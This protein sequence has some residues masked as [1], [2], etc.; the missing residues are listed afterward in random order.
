[1]PDSTIVSKERSANEE[2]IIKRMCM[3]GISHLK[4][5]DICSDIHPII[6]SEVK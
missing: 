2:K 6:P 3:R 4:N 5:S 1:M